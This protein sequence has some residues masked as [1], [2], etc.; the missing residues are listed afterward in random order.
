MERREGPE[1]RRGDGEEPLRL[2]RPSGEYRE[3]YLDF[4]REWKE[5]GET[6]VPWVVD[7]DPVDFEAYLLF[8]EGMEKRE[9][10]PENGVPSSTFWL[11]GR[12]RRVLGAVNLRHE[13][14]EW[15][16]QSGGH[17]GYGIRP[18]QRGR[19]YAAVQLALAL[20]QARERGIPRCLVVCDRD[21]LP[22]ERTIRRCG[23]ER[24]EDYTEED[25]NVIRRFW[26][27]TGGK[28]GL[29]Y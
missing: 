10:L 16:L 4:Y 14:N 17:I 3:A 26:I 13:L 20:E 12:T 25:G 18:S 27:G 24:D 8:L 15:L 1:R 21:N 5:S 23:G 28:G 19:G 9:G 2:V 6:I 11:V 22:S 7:R 29:S